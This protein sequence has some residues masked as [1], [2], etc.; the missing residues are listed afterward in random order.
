MP[1]VHPSF[2]RDE[3]RQQLF[4]SGF[5]LRNVSAKLICLGLHPIRVSGEI[6]VWAKIVECAM[7][8]A[9][10]HCA[11]TVN[12]ISWGKKLLKSDE[13]AFQVRIQRF[14]PPSPD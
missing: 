11:G 12:K 14:L 6:V 1:K 8:V 2:R 9:K 4:E 3:F 13:P 5:T 10:D 7:S